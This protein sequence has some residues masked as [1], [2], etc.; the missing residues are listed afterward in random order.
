MQISD[1]LVIAD[2]LGF[3]KQRH[4]DLT[5]MPENE[6]VSGETVL[7]TISIEAQLIYCEICRLQKEEQKFV[8][9]THSRKVFAENAVVRI[10]LLKEIR[11]RLKFLNAY[12]SHAIN[13]QF[14][15]WGKTKKIGLRKD[16]VAVTYELKG[17][18][19]LFDVLQKFF[20]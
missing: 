20:N 4:I 13:T 16:W 6:V 1:K 11:S 3:R 9:P 18:R 15:L 19:K 14:K 12:F 17:R 8:R 10:F 2:L 7:G 5:A